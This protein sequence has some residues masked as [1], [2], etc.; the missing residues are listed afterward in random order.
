MD[1]AVLSFNRNINISKGVT[2][3]LLL[4]YQS[5]GLKAEFAGIVT[6][7]GKD[8]PSFEVTCYDHIIGLSNKKIIRSFNSKTLVNI[9]KQLTGLNVRGDEYTSSKI[10]TYNA[11]KGARSCVSELIYNYGCMCVMRGRTLYFVKASSFE[12]EDSPVYEQGVSII[13]N[14]LEMGNTLKGSIVVPGSP[15]IRP[16]IYCGIKTDTLSGYY[17][18]DKIETEFSSA[19]FK[20]EIWPTIKHST[21][22]MI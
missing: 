17:R 20:R 16:G 22:Q 9:I 18:V 1:K 11:Q 3:E 10:V 5:T 13:E 7:I 6:D 2:V 14:K 21:R 19:G 8:K 4:G 12:E 15:Y